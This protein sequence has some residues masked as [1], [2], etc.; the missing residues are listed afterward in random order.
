M[1]KQQ[2]N[3]GGITLPIEAQTQT[4]AV[5]GIR[6]SGKTNTAAVIIEELLKHSQQ[7][8][9]IDPTDAWWG[10]KSS[11]DGKHAGFPVVV[12]GGKHS[13]VPLSPNDGALIAD[14]VV[15]QSVSVVLSLRGFESK[16]DELRFV[17][18]FLRRLYYLKGQQ[19]APTPLTLV[20]DE[21]SRHIPQFVKGDA[22]PCVGAVQQIVRQGRTSGFGVIVIDQRA[23]TVNKDVL[24]MLDTLVMHR[25][26]GPRDRKALLGWVEA[27]DVDDRSDEF[28]GSLA[29]LKRGEAWVWS[30]GFLDIFEKVQ[31]RARETFDSSRTPKAGEKRITPKKMADIDLSAIKQK[32]AHTI[33]QARMNDASEL[34]KELARVKHELIVAGQASVEVETVAS[35]KRR[36]RDEYK[37]GLLDGSRRGAQ[38][39][40]RE[41]KTTLAK[42]TRSMV[43]NQRDL[44][45]FVGEFAKRMGE[46][47]K[48]IDSIP[49][50]VLTPPDIAPDTDAAPPPR[51]AT[52][53]APARVLSIAQAPS[54]PAKS[55]GTIPPVQQRVLDA[56]AF[57]AHCGFQQPTVGMVAAWLDYH[58]RTPTF[59]NYLS[60][61][62]TAGL[63][64]HGGG[65]VQ[66]TDAGQKHW[67]LS[68]ADAVMTHDALHKLWLSKLTPVLQR[69]LVPII[70]A[71]DDGITVEALAQRLEYHP[72]T[73]TFRN[74][75]SSLTTKELIEVTRGVAVAR[76]SLFPDVLR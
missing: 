46:V 72:R 40:R 5:L 59:R 21:A 19:D 66:I 15:E 33:E 67:H 51:P 64:V 16:N 69:V 8:V 18:A 34:R 44:L 9:I 36:M 43:S 58:P 31:M 45:N 20:M 56:L 13:D 14:F 47:G 28:M 1:R 60:A 17:T 73:P 53:R 75:L 39:V 3:L 11:A 38:I 57:F 54:S 49:E 71:G 61:L 25:T 62:Q 41:Y 10:L 27:H 12:L 63:I 74:Y 32:L 29:T 65:V 76:A 6:D 24:D 22:A 23:S 68:S 50:D 2:L 42:I 7:A 37:R 70:E 30:P 26:I 35:I 52:R 48:V 4:T 55:D